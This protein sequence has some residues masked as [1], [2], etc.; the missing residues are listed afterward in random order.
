MVFKIGILLLMV[1]AEPLG[2]NPANDTGFELARGM[3]C[4]RSCASFFIY[5]NT[6]HRPR[7]DADTPQ[8]QPQAV[9]AVQPLY[10]FPFSPAGLANSC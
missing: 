1:C 8:G 3:D 2:S 9:P 4:V 6:I 10:S 7:S 5:A